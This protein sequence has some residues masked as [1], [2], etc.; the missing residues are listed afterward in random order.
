MAGKASLT[1]VKEGKVRISP[2]TLAL[3]APS[4]VALLPEGLQDWALAKPGQAVQRRT[5]SQS[6]ETRRH[7]CNRRRDPVISSKSRSWHPTPSG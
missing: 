7:S 1:A 6:H 5:G 4:K 3:Q 2:Y